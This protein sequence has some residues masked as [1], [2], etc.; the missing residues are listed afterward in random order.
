MARNGW[1]FVNSYKYNDMI[2]NFVKDDGAS[3]MRI[4][5]ET[6]TTQAEVWVGSVERGERG[7]TAVG[8]RFNDSC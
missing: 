7:T 8:S 6:L 1:R 3:N 4:T 5:G 2:L